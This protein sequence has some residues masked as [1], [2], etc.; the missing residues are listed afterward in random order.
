MDVR[1]NIRLMERMHKLTK[2]YHPIMVSNKFINDHAI[3]DLDKLTGNE[4]D[5]SK[6]AIDEEIFFYA[7]VVP[8]GVHQFSVKVKKRF[9]TH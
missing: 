4:L 3:V 7:T 1:R 9:S 6:F 5:F 8:P 2:D